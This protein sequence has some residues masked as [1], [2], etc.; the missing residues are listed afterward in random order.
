MTLRRMGDYTGI[1]IWSATMLFT[2]GLLY[3][4]QQDNTEAIEKAQ[5]YKDI[6]AANVVDLKMMKQQQQYQAAWQTEFMVTFKEMVQE[7]KTTNAEVLRNT[8]HLKSIDEKLMK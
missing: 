4:Q 8:Y 1:A 2:M 6:V 3:K 5:K 7:I